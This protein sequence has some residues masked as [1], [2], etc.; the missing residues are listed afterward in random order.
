MN[1]KRL[2]FVAWFLGA[3]IAAATFASC[4]SAGHQACSAYQGVQ[5][6]TQVTR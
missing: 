5:A 6:P 1:S 4:A 3:T 2:S